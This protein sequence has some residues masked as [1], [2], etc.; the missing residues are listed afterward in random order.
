M[1]LRRPARPGLRRKFDTHFA[2]PLTGLLSGED[3]PQRATLLLSVMAGFQVMRQI[4][5]MTGLVEA[6]EEHLARL[7]EPLF[8]ILVCEQTR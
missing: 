7:L 2:T 6:G 4:I 5:G 8:S 1:P 3:R